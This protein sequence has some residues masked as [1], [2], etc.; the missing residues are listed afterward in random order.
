MPESVYSTAAT[1]ST[2][3]ALS[4]FGLALVTCI[5]LAALQ[6]KRR[7]QIPG[8]LIAVMIVMIVVPA[9]AW[10]VTDRSPST[11]HVRLTVLDPANRPV[12]DA[13]VVPSVGNE[14]LKVA[15]GYQIEISSDNR[16]ADGNVTFIA[17]EPG[18]FNRGET[19]LVLGSDK[20]PPAVIH[21]TVDTEKVMVS[22]IVEDRSG[23][24][25]AAQP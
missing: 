9:S 25:V 1:I 4:A 16:P 7:K 2:P 5:I 15:G 13:R 18:S 3:L 11:Y 8:S 10:V 20:N 17:T 6:A 21:M 19:R 12:D 24:A 14:P 23:R 22:G